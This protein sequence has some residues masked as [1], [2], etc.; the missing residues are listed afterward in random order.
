MDDIKELNPLK[1]TEK[2]LLHAN[3]FANLD[4]VFT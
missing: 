3:Y 1:D 2:K 4:I